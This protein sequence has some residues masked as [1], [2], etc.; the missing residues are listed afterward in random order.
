[1]TV[2]VMKL[3]QIQVLDRNKAYVGLMFNDACLAKMRGVV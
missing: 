3:F 2:F 1:M